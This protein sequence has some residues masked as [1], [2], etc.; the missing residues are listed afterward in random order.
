MAT[1]A[2]K[3]DTLFSVL[4]AE[5]SAGLFRQS[6]SVELAANQPL[7][8]AGDAGDGC[9]RVE[10]GLLKVS[11]ASATGTERI[12]AILGP[13][14]LVGELA[15]IDGAPRSASVSAIRDSWLV[16]V[17]RADFDAF[18]RANPEVYRHIAIV[19]AHR[20][21]E[22]DGTL[23]ATSFLSLKGRTA[24]AL[25]NLAQAFGKDVGDGRI[26][27]RQKLSQ[28]DLAAIAGIARENVSRILQDWTRR[29]IVSR[30]A[31]YYCV[32]DKAALEGEAKN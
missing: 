3:P 5:L 12:L 19:L 22:I 10:D 6:R 17:S 25:L 18:C 32:E 30:L 16:F 11:F 23:A 1:P 24:R 21:R 15:M 4:P 8:L 2:A 14:A 31:G 29:A 28:S 20:L 9:Y 27:I 13:G 26:L 7:F